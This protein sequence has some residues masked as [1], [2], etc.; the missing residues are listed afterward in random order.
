MRLM[1]SLNWVIG[2]LALIVQDLFVAKGW[3][4]TVE[5]H[6]KAIADKEVEHYL[7]KERYVYFDPKGVAK[8]RKAL[9]G[10][11]IPTDKFI[12]E[13]YRDGERGIPLVVRMT[14]SAGG[15]T[16]EGIPPMRYV[17]EIKSAGEGGEGRWIK[18]SDA[19]PGFF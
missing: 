2:A 9:G 14:T 8:A 17:Y 18:L 15:V 5:Q 3:R 4:A 1:T 6:A 12:V 16:N 10:V 11:E 7:A 13:A 19:K